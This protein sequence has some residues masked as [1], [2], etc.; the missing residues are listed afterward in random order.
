MNILKV[1]AA[2]RL[3]QN[4]EA[5]AQQQLYDTVPLMKSPTAWVS[6]GE[7]TQTKLYLRLIHPGS[8]HPPLPI[9]FLKDVGWVEGDSA[10]TVI[11]R[12]IAQF[13]CVPLADPLQA[14]PSD[15]CRWCLHVEKMTAVSKAVWHSGTHQVGRHQQEEGE[16]A[17]A[18]EMHPDTAGDGKA[19]YCLS[20]Y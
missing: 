3:W 14:D 16:R 8:V 19:S 11:Q 6:L 9:R 18:K 4:T 7:M 20:I 1:T 15:P 5:N 12:D 17:G 2:Q 10:T 13:V